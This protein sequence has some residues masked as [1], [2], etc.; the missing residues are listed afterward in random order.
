M[1]EP[2]SPLERLL[3]SLEPAAPGPA[4]DQRVREAALRACLTRAGRRHGLRRRLEAMAFATG[5]AAAIYLVLLSPWPP[6]HHLFHEVRHATG[7]LPC[8]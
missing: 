6:A 3:S 8:H 1:P 5:S 2:E 7:I 4:V